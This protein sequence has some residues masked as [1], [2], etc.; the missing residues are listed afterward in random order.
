M[1]Q[2]NNGVLFPAMIGL[3]LGALPIVAISPGN[4]QPAIA[5]ALKCVPTS[6]AWHTSMPS[7][8]HPIRF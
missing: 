3:A 7:G 8:I 1:K 2:T 4:A 5:P 6:P